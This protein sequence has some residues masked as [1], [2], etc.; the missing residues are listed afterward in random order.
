MRSLGIISTLAMILVSSVAQGASLKICYDNGSVDGSATI[1]AIAHPPTG[2]DIV[3][4]DD[5]LAG[6]VL[7]GTVRCSTQPYPAT[8]TPGTTYGV[9]LRGVNTLGQVG[10]SSNVVTFL[11]PNLPAVITGVS[12]QAVTP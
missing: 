11:S 7:T 5:V 3:L 10:P 2:T 1:Q 9:T 6:S 8:L 4:D 12:V